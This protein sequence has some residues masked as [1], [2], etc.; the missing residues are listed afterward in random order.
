MRPWSAWL[1]TA[2]M[3]LSGC[4]DRGDHRPGQTPSVPGAPAAVSM[5]S[6]VAQ[7]APVRLTADLSGLTEKERAM[8]PLLIDAASTMDT[9]FRRQVYPGY[10]SL[11]ASLQDSNLRRFLEIN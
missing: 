6:K 8:L 2:A 3:G 7:Y 9:L 11:L 10:D 4:R 5:G 1:M